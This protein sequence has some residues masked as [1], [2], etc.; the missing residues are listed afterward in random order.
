MEKEYAQ[1]FEESSQPRSVKLA[2]NLPQAVIY[3]RVGRV[4][5]I[6]P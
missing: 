1:K 6:G 5:F 3:V 4:A 2:R